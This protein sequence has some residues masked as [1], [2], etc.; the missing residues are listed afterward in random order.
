MPFA[1]KKQAA[2]CYAKRREALKAGKKP[3]WN[4][5]EWSSHSKFCGSICKDGYPCERKCHSKRCW[6]HQ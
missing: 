2:A 3:K 4:C 6:Q 1:N 5:K